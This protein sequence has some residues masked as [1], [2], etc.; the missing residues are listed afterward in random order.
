M[1]QTKKKKKIQDNI[2]GNNQ[3]KC[4]ARNLRLKLKT[5]GANTRSDGKLF[6]VVI[7]RQLKLWR[8]KLLLQF[9]FYNFNVCPLHSFEAGNEKWSQMLISTY[10]RRVLKYIV[11][12]ALRRLSLRLSIFKNCSLFT[13]QAVFNIFPEPYIIKRY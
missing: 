9:G 4:K 3:G 13:Y 6:H 2:N 12:S 1:Y 8:S 11:R 7:H 10:P 5:E